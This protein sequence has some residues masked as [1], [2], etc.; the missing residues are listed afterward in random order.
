MIPRL[1]PRLTIARESMFG[2]EIVD[3]RAVDLD[4]VEGKAP[5]A[6]G[7]RMSELD[8]TITLFRPVGPVELRTHSGKANFSRP[9][10]PRLARAADLLSRV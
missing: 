2:T 3:E 10:P 4:L 8:E 1:D 7:G 5:S 9:S 6:R